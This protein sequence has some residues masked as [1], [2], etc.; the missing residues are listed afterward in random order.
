MLDA[1][2]QEML[3]FLSG[4][5]GS[6]YTP[7][8]DEITGMEDDGG[9]DDEGPGRGHGHGE[10]P[11]QELREADGCEGNGGYDLAGPD[12]DDLHR[13]PRCGDLR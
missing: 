12:R 4:S 8:S 6:G 10:R 2:R 11:D 1:N 9:R 3:A 7:Q 5:T 13:Q